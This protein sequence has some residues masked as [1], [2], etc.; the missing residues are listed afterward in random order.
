MFV[1]NL[2]LAACAAML[3]L[4]PAVA[5]PPTPADGFMVI[6]SDGTV[7]R[8]S[9]GYSIFK[10]D[11]GSYEVTYVASMHNCADSVTEGTSD[12]TVPDEGFV[13]V[14]SR[15]EAPQIVDVRT[16]DSSGQP[17]DRGFHLIVRC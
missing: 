12:S 17:A 9:K 16:F 15:D 3:T 5:A 13:T 2:S 1:R 4:V 6:N 14:V 8:A 10:Y 7:A 11:V